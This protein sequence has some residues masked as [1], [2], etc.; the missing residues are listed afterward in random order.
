MCCPVFVPQIIGGD[1]APG[2][3]TLKV[4]VKKCLFKA[5]KT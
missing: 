5:D 2:V 1:F 3:V 4:N